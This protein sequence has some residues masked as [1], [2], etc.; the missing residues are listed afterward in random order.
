MGD[1]TFVVGFNLN[2]VYNPTAGQT[3]IAVYKLVKPMYNVPGMLVI[4]LWGGIP[5]DY[6]N[7]QRDAMFSYFLLNGKVSLAVVIPMTNLAVI[8]I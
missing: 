6:L 3:L 5:Y 4:S 2:I 8:D 1:G 7:N